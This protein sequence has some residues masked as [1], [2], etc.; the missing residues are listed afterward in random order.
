M[1]VAQRPDWHVLPHR[2]SNPHLTAHTHLGVLG[3]EKWL[4]GQSV[5]SE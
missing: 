4:R 3:G 2:P 5:M 1:V